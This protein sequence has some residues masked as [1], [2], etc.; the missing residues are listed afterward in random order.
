[1]PR[2]K[3]NTVCNSRVLANNRSREHETQ[4]QHAQR[5]QSQRQIDHDRRHLTFKSTYLMA[6][7][8]VNENILNEHSCGPMNIICV[9]CNST[10]FKEERPA[11]KKFA[12]CCHKGKVLLPPLTEYPPLLRRLL[13]GEDPLPRNFLDH[14]R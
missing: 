1:M 12:S 3:R 14:I 10:N 13:I 2:R 5:L 8:S 7:K 9:T 4:E 11:D 6:L